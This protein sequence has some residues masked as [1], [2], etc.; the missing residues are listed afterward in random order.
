MWMFSFLDICLCSFKSMFLFFMFI[1]VFC[2]SRDCSF[3][4]SFSCSS[5]PSCCSCLSSNIV[6]YH[7]VL[8]IRVFQVNLFFT[9]LFY[10]YYFL[11]VLGFFTCSLL[12]CLVFFSS[13]SSTNCPLNDAPTP[14]VL[15]T[16]W[17]SKVLVNQ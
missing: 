13:C 9:L 16:F 5:S 4:A 7:L 15:F 2:S 14:C 6:I 8:Q 11:H 17:L 10:I 3:G 12:Y 1:Y